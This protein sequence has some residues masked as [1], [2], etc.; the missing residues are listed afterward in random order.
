MSKISTMVMSK[1][2]IISPQWLASKR[3]IWIVVAFVI[4]AL[5]TPTFDPVNQTIM[6]GPLIVLYEISIWLS[7]LVYRKKREVSES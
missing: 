1:F 2:G 7:K 4:A 3:K 6:A 5:I